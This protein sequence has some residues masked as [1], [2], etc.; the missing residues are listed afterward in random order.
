MKTEPDVFSFEDLVRA[1]K[2]TTAWEGVRNYQ[3]RNFM[4]DTFRVGDHVFVYHS[5]SDAPGI[6][7]TAIVV[8]T[9][10]PD[11]T[12]LDKSSKYFDPK[13][14]LIGESRWVMVDIQAKERFGKPMLLTEIKAIK[15][16]AEMLVAKRGQRLSIQP[17]QKFEWDFIYQRSS[18]T[19]V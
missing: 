4:R 9:G 6:Y 15:E 14:A 17:V 5:N 16:L 10:Y 18:P 7:G 13:S 3:A 2:K 19:R 11:H 8:R 1:P 12:A